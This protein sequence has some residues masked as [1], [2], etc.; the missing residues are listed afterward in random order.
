MNVGIVIGRLHNE[1]LFMLK[2]AEITER[3]AGVASNIG[4]QEVYS[5]SGDDML[6]GT[7]RG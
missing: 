4:K 3:E 2:G 7:L 6:A 1:V 5:P